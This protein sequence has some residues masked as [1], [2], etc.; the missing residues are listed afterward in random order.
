MSLSR[1]S[2]SQLYC[3][4]QGEQLERKEREHKVVAEATVANA[5]AVV[6][7]FRQVIRDQRHLLFAGVVCS[8]AALVVWFIVR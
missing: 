7:R 8:I 3:W 2:R 5:A 6:V 1:F 4:R